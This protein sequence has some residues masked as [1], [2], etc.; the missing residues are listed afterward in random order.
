MA[1]STGG[2]L[3][4]RLAV[5]ILTKKEQT[6]LSGWEKTQRGAAKVSEGS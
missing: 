1:R 4:V 3:K 5:K 6:L 2:R